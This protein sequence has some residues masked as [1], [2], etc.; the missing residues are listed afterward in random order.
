MPARHSP[1]TFFIKL[2]FPNSGLEAVIGVA[3]YISGSCGAPAAR[4]DHFLIKALLSGKF[5]MMEGNIFT[6]GEN[7]Y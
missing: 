5:A 3:P 4:I 1:S 7:F 2:C 6:N